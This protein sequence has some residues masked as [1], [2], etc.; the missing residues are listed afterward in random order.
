MPNCQKHV[1][2]TYDVHTSRKKL[3]FPLFSRLSRSHTLHGNGY[4]VLLPP[5][6]HRVS[7]SMNAWTVGD[8]EREKS[9]QARFLGLMYTP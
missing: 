1:F 8:W 6:R 7:D 9:Y 4:Y 3:G 5:V 2:L